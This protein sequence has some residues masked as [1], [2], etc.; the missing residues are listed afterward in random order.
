MEAAELGLFLLAACLVVVALEHPS[1]SLHAAIT[2]PFTRRALTGFAMGVTAVLLIYSPWGK[3]SGAHFNPAVT[4]A[5]YRLGKIGRWDAGFYVVAQMAGA[6]LGMWIS[7]YLLG[8]RLQD[9]SV[10]YVATLP[11]S[12]GSAAAFFA[13]ATI[14]FG[15]MSAVLQL[16]D[17]PR[18]APYTG[19]CAGLLVALYITIE[20]PVSG[21]SMNPARSFGPAVVGGVWQ[22]LWIYFVAPLLGMLAAAEIYAHTCKASGCPK[23]HHDLQYRCIFCGHRPGSKHSGLAKRFP[24]G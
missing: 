2:D 14:S 22:S 24:K 15:M 21:M 10:L 16:S 20:A 5:F 18:L 12:Y 19:I 17:D 7:G 9:S 1:S 11:G 4:L 8:D 23:L 3:Q 6:V 13:E